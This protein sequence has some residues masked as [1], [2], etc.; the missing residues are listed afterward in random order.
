[1]L[2][3]LV[4][5]DHLM[6]TRGVRPALEEPQPRLGFDPKAGAATITLRKRR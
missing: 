5:G 6:V 3:V 1:M 4:A 2:R